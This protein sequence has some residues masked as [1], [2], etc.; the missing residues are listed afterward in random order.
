MGETFSP[1]RPPTYGD[2]IT[3]LSIDGGGIRGII[4]G[5]MLSY[6]ES[7]LQELD[8]ANARLADYFDVVTGTS[9]GGLIAAMLTAPNGDKQPLYAA[10]E[11]VP[12]YLQNAPKIFPQRKGLC[13][14][15]IGL[16]TQLFGPKYNGN[17]LHSLINDVLGKTRL[18][19]SL[20]NIVIPTFDIK[21]QQPT[22]FSSYQVTSN[23]VI[24]VAL[25][26]ICIST[27]AAPTYLPAHYFQNTDADGKLIEFNLIDGGVAA[28][29]P[30]LVAISE[31]TKQALNE[32]P[33]FKE[34]EPLDKDRLLV[35]SLGT[36]SNKREHKY[37][38]NVAAKWGL[39]DWFFDNLSPP[40]VNI[41]TQASS[42]M[43]DYHIAVVFQAL[44]SQ[45]N[46]LRIQDETLSGTLASVDIATTENLE[47][48][49]DFGEQLLKKPVSRANLDTGLYRR[50]RVEDSGTNEDALKRFAKEL[51]RQRR[52]RESNFEKEKNK[53][54]TSVSLN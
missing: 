29:D 17:Y 18:H 3:I 25:S 21:N 54:N 22:I 7:Q 19:Q 8:G 41:F 33:D 37:N 49:V 35:I 43:V 46:Y 40:L 1:I 36:G 39:L 27:S 48:L 23:P 10:K 31:V 16:L 47:K 20:T 2:R 9:T 53:P 28:N 45:D 32:N 13:G 30:A 6:L 42:D 44:C 38:A 34:I 11:I 5:V 15:I 12:F 4:P 51:S 50:V 24:D 14:W 26:D 52:L